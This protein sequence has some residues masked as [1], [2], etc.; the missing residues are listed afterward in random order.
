[1]ALPFLVVIAVTLAF[2]SMV[3]VAVVGETINLLVLGVRQ[4]HDI[5]L[6][7]DKPFNLMPHC[8][9]LIVREHQ[10]DLIPC[11]DKEVLL[12]GLLLVLLVEALE[13]H[14]LNLDLALVPQ[15]SV[16]G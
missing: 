4:L 16:R 2:D 13:V 14:S 5:G 7:H 15:E 6:L 1:M 8:L 10:L 11:V 9:Q 3:W 12:D